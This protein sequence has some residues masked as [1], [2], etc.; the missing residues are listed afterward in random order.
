MRAK[1]I[2]KLLNKGKRLIE[3][4]MSFA[5]SFYYVEKEDLANRISYKQFLKY[6]PICSFFNQ[7]GSALRFTVTRKWY[8]R[9]NQFPTT[10]DGL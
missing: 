5:G 7:A 4:D 3:V 6:K 8:W 1:D 10:I 2:E 9:G